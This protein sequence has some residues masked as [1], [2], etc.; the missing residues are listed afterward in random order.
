MQS[1]NII[2]SGPNGLAAAITLAQAGV[3]VTVYEANVRVGG[4]CSSAA[5][6]LPGFIHDVGSSAYPMGVASPFFRSLP[7]ERYGLRWIEPEIPLAHPFENGST[8]ALD[9]DLAAMAAQLGARD[10]AAWQRLF[11]PLVRRFGDLVPELLGPI[12][13]LPRSLFTLGRFG[14]PALLPVTTLARRRFTGVRAR[15]LFAGCGAHSVMPLDAP[16]SA[17]VGLV[18][19]A[20]GHASGWPVIQGGSQSLSDALAAHLRS[21]GGEIR[22]GVRVSDLAQIEPA[23]AI[24]FDTSADALER[25][26]GDRLSP[27]FR[28][29][30]RGFKHGPGVFKIDWALSQAIPW[31]AE[32]CRRAGTVHVGGTIEEIAAA[33]NA[34]FRGS[35]SDK[36]FVLLVQPSVADSTRAPVDRHTAWGYCHV[37]NGSTENRTEAIEAQIERFAPGFRDCILARHPWTTSALE[38]WN[39]NLVGGDLSGGAMSAKQ[40]LFRPT[41][42][43]YGTS[44]PSIFVCSSCT[45]PGG[46]VHGMCGFHAA[47]MA[48][49]RLSGT[50]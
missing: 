19:A 37:P 7:L 30:L 2:G 13:H 45:P 11:A 15:A 41:V 26:A 18:L 27:G 22:T 17:A 24:F 46:G 42:R 25:I 16:L 31:R 32:N 50:R 29:T 10:G 40:M 6:T 14:L 1:A 12:V 23:D 36:P 39:P 43:E 33:E 4:A 8:A 5:L 9:H 21:L 48:L 47:K 44:D 34:V 3:R 28:T 35:L 49:R 20:A 38:A